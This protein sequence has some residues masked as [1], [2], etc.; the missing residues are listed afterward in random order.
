[1]A[2]DLKQD[3]NSL[4]SVGDDALSNFFDFRILDVPKDI[5]TLSSKLNIDLTKDILRVN[6]ISLP[7]DSL[8][9]QEI[10]IRGVKATRILGA[11]NNT[12]DLPVDII[13][14][15]SWSW[16]K[17]FKGWKD[18]YGNIGEAQ[19]AFSDIQTGKIVITNGLSAD[20]NN[21]IKWTF[22]NIRLPKIGEIS[23]DYITGEPISINLGFKFSGY[24]VS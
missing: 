2:I 23:F 22:Y 6:K 12:L 7:D 3:I 13:V 4:Y 16:Y 8:S 24:E 14:D 15:R 5:K 9:S 18:F 21:F 10:T 17:F 11:I 19:K 1:M 20:D